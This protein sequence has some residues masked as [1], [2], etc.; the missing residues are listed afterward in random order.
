MGYRNDVNT[1]IWWYLYDE[2][3][4]V[5]KDYSEHLKRD[6]RFTNIRTFDWVIEYG[7]YN[8]YKASNYVPAPTRGSVARDS[9]A[10]GIA[11][12]GSAT[13]GRGGSRSRGRGFNQNNR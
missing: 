5:F 10:R 12:R 4:R 2:F 13:R 1:I 9:A 6:L 11:A 7:E 3:L 8:K